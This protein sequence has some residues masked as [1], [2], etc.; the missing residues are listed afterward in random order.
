MQFVSMRELTSSPKQVQGK[1]ASEGN[2]V[3]T[4][5]GSPTML[6]IDITGKDFIKMINYLKRQEALDI[7]H[8]IQVDSARSGRDELTLDD[9]NSEIAAYR[10]SKSDI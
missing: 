6:V 9:I 3:V 8:D 2:I 10:Q 5:N 4:H 1:L 7:L